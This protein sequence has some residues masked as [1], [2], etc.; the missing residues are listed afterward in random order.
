MLNDYFITRDAPGFLLRFIER[1]KLKLPELE[2][3][4][5]AC[6][7]NAQLSYE[8]WWQLLDD[9]DAALG[10]PALGIMVGQS[11]TVEDCGVLGYL[12]R[13]SKHVLDALSCYRRYERLLYAGSAAE[14]LIEQE[15]LTLTWPADQ[16]LS[17]QTSDA[18]LLS[19]LV[20]IIR[21]I[22]NTNDI[23]PLRISFT[24]AIPETDLESYQR[25]FGCRLTFSATRLAIT[26]AL[27]DLLKP[28]PFHDETL[29]RILDQQ[30]ET[31]IADLP[32]Q[33]DFLTGLRNAIAQHLHNGAYTANQAASALNIS[34]R[35]LHRQLQQRGILFRDVLQELRKTLATHYLADPG[36]S[37]AEITL[38]LGYSEQ[39]AF[40]RAHQNWFGRSPKAQRRL[41]EQT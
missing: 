39:S 37:M 34:T 2:N 24:H 20:N 3:R 17:S 21:E 14:A 22:L 6:S 12:F 7:G 31:L 16:G 1:N 27:E 4:L 18:L 35:S 38:L 11:I 19:A 36:L 10:R 40:T 32:E 25:F 28:I 23:L 8:R 30:A 5:L 33:D 26:F 9:L 41:L 13:T 15:E 29:H